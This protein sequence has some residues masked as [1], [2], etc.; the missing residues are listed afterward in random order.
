MTLQANS[1]F[2]MS[3]SRYSSHKMSYISLNVVGHS[4]YVHWLFVCPVVSQADGHYLVQ[5]PHLRWPTGKDD[6]FIKTEVTHNLKR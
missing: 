5:F 1:L 6:T 2:E 4:C 3:E